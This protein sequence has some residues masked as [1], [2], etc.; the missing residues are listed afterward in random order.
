MTDA[1]TIAFYDQSAEDYANVVASD[2]PGQTLKD[3][4]ALLPPGGQVLDLG[5]GP[6]TAS[7]HMRD[8]GLRPDPVDASSGMVELANTRHNIGARILRFDQLDA[9]AA[10]DGVWAN[11]SL[12]HAPEE[13][14]PQHLNAI[15]TA[16][17]PR[18]VLHIGMKTGNGS[19]RDRIDRLY[20]FVTVDA[21][22]GLLDSADFD[23]I[24]QKEGAEKGCAG[25]VD[26]Y[27]IMRGRKRG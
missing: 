9:V 8:A 24:F 3:F 21:L 1:R 27:V 18:G 2:A 6:A 20:T 25:T 19:A 16:L 15:T 12:L 11:F 5:C 17:R 26:P 13:D 10:Y 22:H 14:L 4:I 7:A 23:I